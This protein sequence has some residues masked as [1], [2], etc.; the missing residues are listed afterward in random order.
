MD[1]REELIEML[2]Q[3]EDDWHELPHYGLVPDWYP[4]YWRLHILIMKHLG[5][6]EEYGGPIPPPK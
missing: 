4:R 6:L 1:Y 3:N 5:I 2:Y